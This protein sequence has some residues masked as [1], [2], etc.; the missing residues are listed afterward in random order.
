MK[1][2]EI[3]R[4]AGVC[5]E[6]FPKCCEREIILFDEDGQIIE[7]PHVSF[8]PKLFDD[9]LDSF[10]KFVDFLESF[11]ATDFSSVINVQITMDYV[12]VFHKTPNPKFFLRTEPDDLFDCED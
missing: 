1:L 6:L 12:I 7:E 2:V 5:T 11:E 10:K 9:N 8:R 3:M 4:G